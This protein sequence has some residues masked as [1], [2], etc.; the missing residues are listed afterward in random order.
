MSDVYKNPETT[1]ADEHAEIRYT[2]QADWGG[3]YMNIAGPGGKTT[4]LEHNEKGI[5]EQGLFDAMSVYKQANLGSN[6]DS[7]AQ[8]AYADVEVPRYAD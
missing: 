7:H 5:L 2:D 4:N 3:V 6:H 8:G 1:P